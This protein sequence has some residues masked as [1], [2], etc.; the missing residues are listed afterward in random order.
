MTAIAGV[1][2]TNDAFVSKFDTNGTPEWVGRISSDG[3]QQ[4]GFDPRR[5]IV[6]VDATT[7]GC[8]VNC[9]LDTPSN[10]TTTLNINVY[11]RSFGNHD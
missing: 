8:Y 7:D 9:I 6:S 2:G 5:G 10:T 1:S 11:T 4:G 3:S